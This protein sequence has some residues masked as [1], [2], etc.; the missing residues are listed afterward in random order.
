[1]KRL[2]HIYV[3]ASVAVSAA[4]FTGRAQE[5]RKIELTAQGILARV[6][7][8]MEYPQ[9]LIRG[10]IKHITPDGKSTSIKFTASIAKEDFLFIFSSR[11]RGDQLKVLF[12]LGG[13]DVW[14]YNVHALKLYH[15]RGIDKYDP[16]LATNFFFIDIS[17][18]D[19]Q[20]NYTA[21]IT[22]EAVVQGNDAYSLK[23]VPV[24]KGGDYGQLTL[25]VSKDK[26]LPLRIDFHDRDRAIFKFMTLVKTR[27][28]DGRIQPLQYDMMNIRQ[29]TVSI[30]SF[31]EYDEGQK[32]GREIF[33]PEKLGD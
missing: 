2:F 1:M 14:V 30:M 13:E 22:G 12:N 4:V 17:N 28:K 33:R 5:E 19:L 11:E 23:L 25:Y 27:E 15:K 7:K 3:I 29:G 21:T 32:F 18:A 24:F 26:Y 8:I 16:V 31:D 20:S 10:K 6:D 9:G